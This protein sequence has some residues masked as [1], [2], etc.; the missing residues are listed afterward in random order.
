MSKNGNI[1]SLFITMIGL[2]LP[3]SYLHAELEASDIADPSASSYS[4]QP[5]LSPG[6]VIT[7]KGFVIEP[8]SQ[9]QIRQLNHQGHRADKDGIYRSGKLDT[10]FLSALNKEAGLRRHGHGHSRR[11][12]GGGRYV[13]GTSGQASWYGDPSHVRDKF[14][15]K[16]SA[17]GQVFNTYNMTIAC[18]GCG[19][20]R[21]VRITNL[22]NGAWVDAN[23]TD[24]GGFGK[25]GR[26]ADVSWGV[27]KRIG[28]GDLGQVH[29]DCY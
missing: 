23:V 17:N 18:N 4:V 25:Y 6:A 14:H 16:R 22:N 28:M 1:K 15:G 11:N 24:T 12:Q 13:C 7:D 10:S 3:F 9:D 8:L 29:I 27:K 5:R 19:G 2:A 26:I 20:F 21:A